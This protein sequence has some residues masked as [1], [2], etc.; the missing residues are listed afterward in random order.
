MAS[1]LEATL[2]RLSEKSRFITERFRVVSRR[3]DEAEARIAELEKMVRDR[4]RQIQLMAAEIENL[5]VSSVLA[6]TAEAVNATRVMI[7]ELIR[8][9]DRCIAD[10]ND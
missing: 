6:P 2:N 1:D 5:R 10:I 7:R 8:D 3:K 9:I 4:D